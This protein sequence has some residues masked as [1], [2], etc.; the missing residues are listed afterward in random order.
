MNSE[1]TEADEFADP[2]G[3]C[4]PIAYRDWLIGF[5]GWDGALPAAVYLVP[6]LVKRLL[7]NQPG[8]I[9]VLAIVLPIAALFCR[10]VAGSRVIKAN[11]CC[12]W[13]RRLQ[14]ASFGVALLILLLIDAVLTLSRN[15]PAGALFAADSDRVVWT[16]LG[17]TYLFNML[18]A[19]Y[20]GRAAMGSTF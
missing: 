19:M 8:I 18:F 15:M 5:L 1:P 6:S 9:E 11:H 7:P 17:V 14:F 4:G 12:G 16:I 13:C 10:F 2:E 20:P 3:A